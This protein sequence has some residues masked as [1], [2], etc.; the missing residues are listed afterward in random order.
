VLSLAVSVPETPETLTAASARAYFTDN[1][2]ELKIFAASLAA[3]AMLLL[4]LVAQLRALI[5]RAEQGRG[6]LADV[7]PGAGG[8]IAVWL[9]VSAAFHGVAAFDGVDGRPDELVLAYFG[10]MTSGD[11]LGVVSTFAKG[12]LMLAVGLAALRTRF[13]PRWLGWLSVVLGAMAVGGG[14][15]AAGDPVTG[16]LWYGGL[17]GFAIWPLLVATTLIVKA[18][19]ARRS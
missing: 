12:A 2:M 8:L 15:G 17:L 11:T 3:S 9:L 18:L 6:F 14:F 4:V 5:A 1:A 7:V 13:L 16:A 19:R 10:L